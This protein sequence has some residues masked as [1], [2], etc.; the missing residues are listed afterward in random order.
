MEKKT[1]LSGD[2]NLSGKEKKAICQQV[3]ILRTNA[4][5]VQ[6]C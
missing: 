3:Q 5:Q 2:R 1:V 4:V 6:L